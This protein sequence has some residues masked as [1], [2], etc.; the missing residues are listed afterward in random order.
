VGVIVKTGTFPGIMIGLFVLAAQVSPLTAQADPEDPSAGWDEVY[1]NPRGYVREPSVF[2]VRCVE[3]LAS[4]GLSGPGATALVLAMGDGRNA[5][6][7]AE[8]GYD[9]TGL[10][11]SKVGIEKAEAAAAAAGVEIRAVRAD[12]FKTDLGD[13]IWDLVTNIYFN[14]AVKI[15]DRIKRAVRP[16][17]FLIIE[18]FGSD[19]DG[20][21]APEWSRYEPNQLL[22]ELEGWRILEYQDGTYPA[23]WAAGTPVPLIRVLAKKPKP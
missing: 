6:E 5:I 3:R 4:E 22:D 11:I 21:G 18:G 20:P 1:R 17:G 23:D 12:M 9:V 15:L 10:D 14:P 8:R 16:G 7:L 2:L 13:G 19:Y